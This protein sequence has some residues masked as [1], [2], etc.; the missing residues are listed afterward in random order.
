[1]VKFNNKTP[2]DFIDVVVVF[3]L[4]TLNIFD[5][6]F[7]CFCCEQVNVGWI[8]PSLVKYGFLI[9]AENCLHKWLLK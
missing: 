4:L 5:T 9:I 7:W 1:M 2:E 6:F 8:D 3:L